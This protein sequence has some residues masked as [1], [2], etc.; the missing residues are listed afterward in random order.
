MPFPAS[1]PLG[2]REMLCRPLRG[3][4][5]KMLPA[6]VLLA[7]PACT[8]G[9]SVEDSNKGQPTPTIHDPDASAG[10]DDGG[11]ADAGSVIGDGGA[12]GYQGSPLCNWSNQSDCD[13]DQA[14]SPL[15]CGATDA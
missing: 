11:G 2:L 10:S 8:V 15:M 3:S 5:L 1:V 9:F 6:L 4:F 7:A 14:K 12:I 13:P